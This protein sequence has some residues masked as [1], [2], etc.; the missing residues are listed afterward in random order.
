M[1]NISPYETEKKVKKF[2]K[3]RIL[4]GAAIAAL[5]MITPLAAVIPANAHSLDYTGLTASFTGKVGDAFIGSLTLSPAPASGCTLN[6]QWV[7]PNLPPGLSVSGGVISGTPTAS[8]NS[9]ASVTYSC[10]KSNGDLYRWF[11]TV[12][13]AIA[14]A[15]VL[16]PS[17]PP[18]PEPTP[19][20]EV[21]PQQGEAEARV[22]FTPDSPK[23]G[24]QAINRIKKLV[25]ELPEGAT[26]IVVTITGYIHPTTETDPE[27]KA[28]RQSLPELRAMRVKRQL[29]KLGIEAEFVVVGIKTPLEADP[30]SRRAVITMSYTY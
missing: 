23:L 28:Y 21:E 13:F 4:S 14:P 25:K 3:K 12:S 9:S 17:N 5:A 1:G 24:A 19:E 20:P 22:F 26:N 30:K 2:M 16:P 27:L 18:T 10:N 8:G 7:S 6:G 29:A 11:Y 15:D